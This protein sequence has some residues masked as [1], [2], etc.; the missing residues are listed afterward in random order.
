MNKLLLI[1]LIAIFAL[2]YIHTESQNSEN[3]FLSQHNGCPCHDCVAYVGCRI[4][5]D[6]LGY[7]WLEFPKKLAKANSS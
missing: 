6:K 7:G 1:S 2:F 3:S 4:G 5:K